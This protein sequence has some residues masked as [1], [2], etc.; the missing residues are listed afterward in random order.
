MVFLIQQRYV[1]LVLDLGPR[2]HPCTGTPVP[3]ARIHPSNEA[4]PNKISE[5]EP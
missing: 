5:R 4:E 1:L 3:P 2:W